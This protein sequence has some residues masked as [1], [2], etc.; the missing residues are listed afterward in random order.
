VR[1]GGGP[2]KEIDVEALAQLD[3]LVPAFRQVAGGTDP[4]QLDDRTPCSEWAVRDL[5]A[6]LIGGATG[7]AA[8]VRGEQPP[9]VPASADDSMAADAVA[10][11]GGLDAAFHEPGALERTVE[12]PFGPMPGDAFARLAAFDLLMHTWDLARTTGQSVPVDDEVVAAV[13]GFARQAVTPELRT[14]GVFGPE[15]E[16]PPSASALERLVAFSGR[17]P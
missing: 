9:D 10:A 16:A 4:A 2:A 8:A 14:P 7:F 11:V 5:F 6:H 3:V 1:G 12:T 15:V 17:T 13:D